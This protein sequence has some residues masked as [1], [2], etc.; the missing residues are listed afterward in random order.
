MGFFQP[1]PAHTPYSNHENVSPLVASRE[2]S[3]QSPFNHSHL[4]GHINIGCQQ[5]GLGCSLPFRSGSRSMDCP[6]SRDCLQHSGAESRLSGTPVILPSN[7]GVISNAKV[8]QY[9][10]GGLHKEARWNSQLLSVT[11]SGADNELGSEV[12]VQHLGSLHSGDSECTGGLPLAGSNGQQRV[13]SPQRVVRVASDPGSTSRGRSVCFPMQSQN[14]QILFKVQR[15]SG[16]WNRCSLR[17]ME[18]SEGL[19]LPS[20]T[21]DSSISPEAQ[22]RE[23]GDH[24][25]D[26]FLAQQAVVSSV[27]APELPRPSSPTSQARI[28]CLKARCYTHAHPAYTSG[29]GS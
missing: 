18:V 12:I 24:C 29:C 19:C 26:S 25:S 7:R 8:G 22:N 13:V 20:S 15:P 23:G 17:P 28:Y 1:S 5:S 10:R 27:I 9:N 4:M 11:G 6:C 14:A 2:K 3:A 16:I 21:G